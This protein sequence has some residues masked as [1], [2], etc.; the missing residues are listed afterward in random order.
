MVLIQGVGVAGS[1][2]A[3][4]VRALSREFTCLTFDNRGIG[5]SQPIGSAPVSVGQMADDTWWLMNRLGWQS[6]HVIGHSLGGPVALEMALTEPSRARSLSLLCTLARGRGATA[7][8]WRMLWLGL[9]CRIGPRR[10]RRHAFLEIVM[11]PAALEGAD[12][13]ALAAELAPLFG[14]DL[15]DQ[16]PVAMKQLVALR[17]YDATGRLGRITH[18]PTLVMSALHD[19]IAPPR[20]GRALAGAIPGA[21][22]VEFNDAS[23]G[24]PIQHATRVNQLLLEH[25]RHAHGHGMAEVGK[26][27]HPLHH[28][29]EYLD[30]HALAELLAGGADPNQPGPGGERPLHC[31]LDMELV[32]S[33]YRYYTGDESAAPRATFTRLLLSAGADPDLSDERG[34]T[35]RTRAR[36]MHKEALELFGREAPTSA[37]PRP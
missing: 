18:T 35:P 7:L 27:P 16:P 23:H 10:A 6:A 2:W 19:P 20:H 30:A 33:T 34:E 28:A 17:A 14:H 4:Q 24:L 1:G 32:N 5:A 8:T 26:L 15:A 29:I 12:R 22:Y 13:D 37:E 9:R 31:A 11:P 21:A 3:P 36:R 25:L